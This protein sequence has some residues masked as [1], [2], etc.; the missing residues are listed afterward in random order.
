[1]GKSDVIFADMIPVRVHPGLR[2]WLCN[3]VR[4]TSLKGSLRNHGSD[5]EDSVDKKKTILYFTY[6]SRDTLKSFTL[7]I[8][9]KTIPKLNPEHSDK[10]ELKV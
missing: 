2:L 6:E 1:M 3:T 5:A 7:F 9:A 4:D 10:F 8:T